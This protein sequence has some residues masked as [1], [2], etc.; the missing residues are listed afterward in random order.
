M[1][2]TPFNFG[3]PSPSGDG[4]DPF[5]H[6]APSGPDPFDT[7]SAPPPGGQQ[8]PGGPASAPPPPPGQAPA[9]QP[10]PFGPTGGFGDAE[11]DAA[12]AFGQDTAA[13]GGPIEISRPPTYLLF[14]ALAIAIIAAVVAG[15]FG[16]PVVAIICWVLAGPIA[17]GIIALFVTKDNNARGA[18]VYVAPG[19]LRAVHIIASVVCV[20]AVIVPALRIAFWVGRL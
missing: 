1:S 3:A 12:A 10:T 17:I 11:P 4:G 6:P 15:I 7:S 14:I 5:A 18:G 13:S 8:G 16:Q 2:Q 20:A 9:S 19:W